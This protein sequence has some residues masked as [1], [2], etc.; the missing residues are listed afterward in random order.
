M[1]D[2]LGGL[3]HVELDDRIGEAELEADDG[4]EERGTKSRQRLE[5]GP[6]VA[7]AEEPRIPVDRAFAE[8]ERRPAQRV[9]A[10]GEDEVGAALADILIRGVDR[11]HA[12]AAIDLHRER[13][14][15]L[16]HAETK[17]GDARGIHLVGDDVDA[18]EDDLV[19][20]VGGKRLAQQQRPPAGDG[21]I[22]RRERARPPARADERRAAAV[23]DVNR[24]PCYAAAVGGGDVGDETSPVADSVFDADLLPH[25][26][27][28]PSPACGGG[29]G[30]GHATRSRGHAKRFICTRS[31]P[32]HPSPASGGGSRPSSPL[33]L[34]QLRTNAASPDTWHHLHLHHRPPQR[35]RTAA[36]AAGR[37]LR[38]NGFHFSGTGSADWRGESA[39]GAKSSTATA[40]ATAAA[41]ARSSFASASVIN[42]CCRAASAS[43]MCAVC[44]RS[45]SGCA[46]TVSAKARSRR[47]RPSSPMPWKMS[48]VSRS[49]VA[50]GLSRISALA[51]VSR[52]EGPRRRKPNGSTRKR[53]HHATGRL[54]KLA[55]IESKRASMVAKPSSMHHATSGRSARWRPSSSQR[56]STAERR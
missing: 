54:G 53:R 18:A 56:L 10:A 46:A 45:R 48:T 31:P 47:A 9:G 4:L 12:G 26:R 27:C 5:A 11:L 35:S 39:S 17:R 28:V 55:K 43:R 38:L 3:P 13:G 6:D 16:A 33:A 7:G 49:R 44:R 40:A 36:E 41:A 15:R 20:G 1:A 50:D 29:I 22:D 32:P 42:P 8:E 37:A 2:D 25:A 52:S 23:D 14:H 19:E 34:V 51:R 30:R 21:E 24:A